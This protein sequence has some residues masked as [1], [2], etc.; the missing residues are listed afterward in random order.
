MP[1]MLAER[2]E[3]VEK[4]GEGG[5]AVVYKARCTYLDRWV[6][7]KVLRDQ[8]ASNPEF[9]DRFQREA[10][11]AARLAHPNIVSIY[12]VGEDQGRHFIVMEYVQGENLKDYLRSHGPLSP[13]KVAQ[14]GQQVATALA[15]AHC[16]GII[17]RDIKPHNLLI[18]PEGQVKVTDFGIARAAA[19]SSLTETGM[20]LGSVHYFSPEQA[21]GEAV[22][23]RSDIYALGVVLYELL[24]GQ[25]PFEGDSPI[26]VALRHLDSE[27][28]DLTELCPQ[29]PEDLKQIIMKAMAKN[30]VDRYQTAGELSLALGQVGGWVRTEEDEPTQILTTP[31]L[32]ADLGQ[33]PASKH[34]RRAMVWTAATLVL[35]AALVGTFFLFRFYFLVPVVEV[36]PLVGL[37]AEQAQRLLAEK[38]LVYEVIREQYSEEPPGIVLEQEPQPGLLRKSGVGE[39]VRVVLSQGRQMTTVPDVRGQTQAG[40]EAMLTQN[41]LIRGTIR[42][43]YDPV[44]PPGLVL[45]Q[46]PAPRSQLPVGSQVGI[47]LSLGPPPQPVLVPELAG[48]DIDSAKNQLV[49]LGLDVSSTRKEPSNIF[50]IDKVIRTEPP[51]GTTVTE[52]DKINLIISQGPPGDS[53]LELVTF[54]LDLTVPDGSSR[55]QVEVWVISEGGK[56]QRVFNKK[57]GPG[58]KVQQT[59]QA[60]PQSSIRVYLDGEVWKEY[61]VSAGSGT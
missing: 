18:T 3:L 16:R 33:E 28:R 57:L 48:Q 38:G 37:T 19:A 10:R 59:L 29:V 30:P 11:A 50:G 44:T 17:H 47:V 41:N 21:R 53:D 5:M 54:T 58:E 43:E 20:V 52:G 7:I 22:D 31:L 9:L 13:H 55:R 15:H 40:A 26:A 60:S 14:V 12:D 32:K 56:K 36:P 49:A 24:T 39:K 4:I 1:S 35:L 46:E 45:S 42:E 23:A 51:A 25:L 34:N 2:Y 27:P 8:Y 6:A 61:P